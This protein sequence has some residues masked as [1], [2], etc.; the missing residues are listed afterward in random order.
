MHDVDV[1]RV[2]R[3]APIVQSSAHTTAQ[4][5]LNLDSFIGGFTACRLVRPLFLRYAP[6]EGKVYAQ[7]TRQTSRALR[8]SGAPS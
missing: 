6:R 3:K 1:A 5:S 7:P 4:S 8:S 2:G